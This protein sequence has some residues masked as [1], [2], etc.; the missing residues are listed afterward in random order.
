MQTDRHGT[1]LFIGD[2]VSLEASVAQDDRCPV[3]KVREHFMNGRHHSIKRELVTSTA[4]GQS[5]RLHLQP[6]AAALYSKKLLC[7]L[8]QVMDGVKRKVAEIVQARQAAEKFLA[9]TSGTAAKMP[10]PP[11]RLSSPSSTRTAAAAGTAS[12]SG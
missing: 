4:T 10:E 8:L 12:S 3:R 11:P 1:Q 9:M 6:A 7:R 2:S 5:R